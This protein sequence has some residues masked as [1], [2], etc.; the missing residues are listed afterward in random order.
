MQY[1]FLVSVKV[2]ISCRKGPALLGLARPSHGQRRTGPEHS[3]RGPGTPGVLCWSVPS[4]YPGGIPPGW[5]V[6]VA[7]GPPRACMRACAACPGVRPAALPCLSGPH[8]AAGV[9]VP[10]RAPDV[11]IPAAPL[12]CPS[13][14]SCLLPSP[15]RTLRPGSL[16]LT[17]RLPLTSCV[18]LG[19]LNCV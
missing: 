4:C 13:F 7:A 2:G 3:W 17:V 1:G 5:G 15:P 19:R 10:A 11:S 9:P 6:I 16:G 14:S 8:P 12:C 18:A